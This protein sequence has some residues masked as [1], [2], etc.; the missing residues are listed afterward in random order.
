[1]IKIERVKEKL[2]N[3]F[4]TVT[5]IRSKDGEIGFVCF[6][7]DTFKVMVLDFDEAKLWNKHKK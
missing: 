7:E 6:D 2:E 4:E 1:M 5:I 3:F